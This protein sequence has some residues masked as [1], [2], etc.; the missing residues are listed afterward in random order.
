MISSEEYTQLRH[1]GAHI[2]GGE[3]VPQTFGDRGLFPCDVTMHA[4]HGREKLGEKIV[5]YKQQ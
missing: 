4:D 3:V 2:I 5:D 1:G